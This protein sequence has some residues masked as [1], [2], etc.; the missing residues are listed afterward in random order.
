MKSRDNEFKNR[1][2][3]TE[4]TETVAYHEVLSR[5]HYFEGI[6]IQKGVKQND[7]LLFEFSKACLKLFPK[8]N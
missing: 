3:E 8:L 6:P 5:R 4:T 1:T 2:A 7:P